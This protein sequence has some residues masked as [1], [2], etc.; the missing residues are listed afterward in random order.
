[1]YY[2]ACIYMHVC[3]FTL[4][5]EKSL[6]DDAVLLE[7]SGAATQPEAEEVKCTIIVLHM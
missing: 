3:I 4:K 1:M 2:I 6:I 5:T 7:H